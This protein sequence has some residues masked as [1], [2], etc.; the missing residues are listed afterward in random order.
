MLDLTQVGGSKTAWAIKPFKA[1]FFTIE[2]TKILS[3]YRGL[4]NPSIIGGR[5][6]NCHLDADIVKAREWSFDQAGDQINALTYWINIFFPFFISVA[7]LLLTSLLAL[8]SL[9]LKVTP[10]S[11]I[12]MT[13]GLLET[14]KRAKAEAVQ[15]L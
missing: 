15:D 1:K 7:F 13:S 3:T 4:E 8:C 12:F 9:A 6:A 10:S 2:G 14:N 5:L 11:R